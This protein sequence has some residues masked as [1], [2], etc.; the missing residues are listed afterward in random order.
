MVEEGAW[1]AWLKSMERIHDSNRDT[2]SWQQCTVAHQ[3]K[4]LSILDACTTQFHRR[5]K[6]LCKDDDGV[7][8]SR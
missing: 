1:R 2:L 8:G 6:R 4:I 5:E 3:R 7:S